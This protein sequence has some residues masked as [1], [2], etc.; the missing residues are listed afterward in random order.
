[1]EGS[2]EGAV[3]TKFEDCLF[4]EAFHMDASPSSGTDASNMYGQII[5]G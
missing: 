1:M 4:G 3:V 2:V 5:S